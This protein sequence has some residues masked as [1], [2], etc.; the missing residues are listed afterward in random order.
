MQSYWECKAKFVFNYVTNF[1][2]LF[3]NKVSTNILI[4]FIKVMTESQ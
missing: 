4:V 2:R 1:L 3:L